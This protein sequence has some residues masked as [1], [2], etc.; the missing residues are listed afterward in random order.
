MVPLAT[1]GQEPV[2]AGPTAEVGS[3]AYVARSDRIH[4]P[5]ANAFMTASTSTATTGS[6]LVTN[7]DFA[8]GATGW[9]VGAN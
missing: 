6:N 3:Q 2:G 8:A 4:P 1:A 7:G 9:T 5:T